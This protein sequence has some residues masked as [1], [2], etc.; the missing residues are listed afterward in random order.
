[1]LH[2]QHAQYDGTFIYK[3]TKIAWL[4]YPLLIPQLVGVEVRKWSVT[5]FST[6]SQQNIYRKIEK[7]IKS[8]KC[9][10]VLS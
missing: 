7:L 5:V 8:L 6:H 3:D 9:L 4:V 10:F 1:M 2:Y